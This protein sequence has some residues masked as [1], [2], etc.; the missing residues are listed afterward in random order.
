M[1]VPLRNAVVTAMEIATLEELFPGRVVAG[2]GHGVQSWL[3]QIDARATSPLTLLRENAVAIKD[4]LAGERISRSGRYVTLSDAELVWPP[5]KAPTLFVAGQGPKTLRLVGEV[6]DATIFVLGATPDDVRA[7]LALINEGRMAAGRQAIRVPGSPASDAT[8][9]A[10]S[11]SVTEGG[12]GSSAIGIMDGGFHV[13][14]YIGLTR[15]MR[16]AGAEAFAEHLQPW[17][18]AGVTTL[19]VVP[20]EDDGTTPD[21]SDVESVAAWLGR[22]VRPLVGA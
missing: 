17:I 11:A 20:V 5:A 4:L 1:P 16:A 15:E 12:T 18:E 3:D 7:N 14:V 21:M 9:E 19:A 2:I 10:T 8:S 22:E 6:G 13:C